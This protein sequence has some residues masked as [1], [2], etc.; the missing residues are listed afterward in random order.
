M[1]ELNGKI[2]QK[3]SP[4][5]EYAKNYINCNIP[6]NQTVE[7]ES[8]NGKFLLDLIAYHPNLDTKQ[9]DGIISFRKI[10]NEFGF[11]YSLQVMRIDE[12]TETF[13]Y[14]VCLDFHY[15]KLNIAMRL[16]I[17]LFRDKWRQSNRH[18]YHCVLCGISDTLLEVDHKTFPFAEIKRRFLEQNKLPNP[19]YARAITCRWKFD[20]ASNEYEKSWVKFHDS[21][22]DYQF[23]C[24][25]CNGKKSDKIDYI[26][27]ERN[28][29][30]KPIKKVSTLYINV[31]DL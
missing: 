30:V 9:G 31:N 25:Q 11:G 15:D 16:S 29:D 5:L 3:K 17:E 2:F 7:L 19:S 1:Y 12:T 6:Y 24:G 4:A 18:N 14:K 21:L 27:N 13:S 22:V 23:L 10:K 28:K 8:D 20:D 26:P